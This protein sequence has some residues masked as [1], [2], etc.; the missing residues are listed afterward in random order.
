MGTHSHRPR[1]NPVLL[2]ILLGAFCYTAWAQSVQMHID[3]GLNHFYK[4]RYLEAFQEFRNALRID[5]QNADAHYNLGRVYL[6]QG[7]I[8]EA[9]TQFEAAVSF[10]PRH[11]AA[12]R[13]LNE[14]R[15]RIK[16]DVTLQ[17]KLQ[18]QDEA[19]RQRL[20]GGKTT[21]AQQQA[22]ALMKNGD[23]SG[24]ALA[25]E[26]AL[27]SDPNNPQIH[28]ILGFLHFRQNRFT[29]ALRSYER[30]QTLAASD[31][32]IPYSIGM[33]Y[34]R[35]QSPKQSLGPLQQAVQLSPTLVKAQFALGEA[36]EAL[37]QF[38]D[39]LFQY[40]KCL[41]INPQLAQAEERIQSMAKMLGFTY[42][43][44]GSYYYQQGDYEKAEALLALAQKYGQL[45]PDQARQVD[46]MLT[47]ARFW[48]GKKRTETRRNTERREITKSSYTNMPVSVREVSLNP[49]LY[50]G[51]AVEWSGYAICSETDLAKPRF[52]VNSSSEANADSNLDFAF[53]VIF[54]K[55]LPDD[56]RVSDYSRLSVKG[57]IVGV[58]KIHNSGTNIHSSR[59]QPIIEATEVTFTRENYEQPL[60]LRYF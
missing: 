15:G 31:A 54:P 10:N 44:R 42:F 46:E 16:N 8:K 6:I 5:P 40:R 11:V 22:E 32:E 3:V 4:K 51:R 21:P 23:F 30:A 47:A 25:F 2:A 34:L 17:L 18:G 48:V 55:S 49:K 58:E 7:F 52:Y 50:Q 14:L 60:T 20:E 13:D 59:R 12:A 24:A 41:E 26:Q 39:A 36:Y 45:N 57:K 38:E 9:V 35:T 28:K 53:G 19:L 1:L 27:K 43:S 56:P 29:D 37:G 33:V